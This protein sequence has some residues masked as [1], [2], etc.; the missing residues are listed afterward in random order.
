MQSAFNIYGTPA[1]YSRIKFW[2]M[3]KFTMI[4][5]AALLLVCPV[6]TLHAG[7]LSKSRVRSVVSE[8]KGRQGFEVINV[9]SFL[10][11]T[12]RNGLRIALLAEPDEDTKAVL[13]LTRHI[14]SCIVVDYEDADISDKA[15]FSRRISKKLSRHELLMEAKDDGDNVRIYGIANDDKGKVSDVVVDVAGEALIC[16]FGSI[17]TDDIARLA[18]LD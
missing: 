11:T 3:K 17:S 14:K 15:D 5:A 10:M 16:L 6:S 8:Y 18:E 4:L 7:S 1:S 2:N 9:G 12:L 13:D